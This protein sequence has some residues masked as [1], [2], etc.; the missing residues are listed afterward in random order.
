MKRIGLCALVLLASCGVEAKKQKITHKPAHAPEKNILVKKLEGQLAESSK[1]ISFEGKD[2]FDPEKKRQEVVAMVQKA[3]TFLEKHSLIEFFQQVN[4]T[5]DF[6]KGDLFLFVYDDKGTSLARSQEISMLWKNYLQARDIFGM[7]YI[8]RLLEQAQLG[9]GWI[10]YE[11]YD[12]PKATYVKMAPKNGK[13]YMLG[14]GYYPHSKE[15][16]VIMLVRGAVATFYDYLNRGDSIDEAFSDFSFPGG[17]FVIG[18]FYIYVL[19]K[20]LVIRAN[21]FD[22]SEVGVS[23]WNV[24]DSKGNYYLRQIPEKLANSAP[25]E[26]CWVDF[27]YYNAPERDYAERIVDKKGNSYY[28]VSGYNPYADRE[29]AVKLVQRAVAA[30]KERGL[31]NVAATINDIASQEFVYGRMMIF[32]YDLEG[33]VI[34]NGERPALVGK[35]S[36]KALDETGS[37]YVKEIIDKAKNEKNGWLSFLLKNAIVSMYVEAIEVEGKKYIV[38][39]KIFPVSK[40]N[41]VLLLVKSAKLQLTQVSEAK[42]FRSFNESPGKYRLGDLSVFVYGTDGTCYADGDAV[43]NVW[44]NMM[45]EQDED[46]RLYVKTMI[47]M[48]QAGPAKVIFR[49][50]GARMVASVEPVKKGN[51]T[52]IVGSGYYI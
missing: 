28:I 51:K 22:P 43:D 47:Q 13:N 17:K 30:I 21:G 20:D 26:G 36:I 6:L 11:K 41:A 50:D 10:T 37:F 19:D 45:N 27:E 44:R 4:L 34:A 29:M 49:K 14:C 32:I 18:E 23:Y 38:G 7:Q 25:G 8:K 2:A 31:E 3:E 24:A 46:G 1:D 42:A 39:A 52:Y 5:K 9:G 35:N 40:E 12:A 16:A 48:G 33:N 15:D